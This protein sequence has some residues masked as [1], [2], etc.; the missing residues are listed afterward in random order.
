MTNRESDGCRGSTGPG[1]IAAPFPTLTGTVSGRVPPAAF[2]I[3][4]RPVTS[5][6]TVLPTAND[7][8]PVRDARVR[9]S[10]RD[11]F[12]LALLAITIAGAFWSGKLHA[13]QERVIVVPGPSSHRN[14]VT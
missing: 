12:F 13:T 10:W 6:S 11:L 2:V 14:V 9:S 1:R 7:N 8:T 3:V 5:T 4:G